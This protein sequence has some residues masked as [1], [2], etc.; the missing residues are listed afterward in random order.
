AR[1]RTQ[2]AL[3]RAVA[4]ATDLEHKLDARNR[5]LEAAAAE[6]AAAGDRTRRDLAAAAG[7]QRRFRPARPPEVPGIRLAW[8]FRPAAELAVD[9][10]DAFPADG[11]RLGVCAVDG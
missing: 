9:V 7:V 3:R 8:A 4:R 1:I 11:R 2:L 6:L 5:E 10:L